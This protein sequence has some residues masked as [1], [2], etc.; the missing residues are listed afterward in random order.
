MKTPAG[1]ECKYFYGDYYRGRDRE[2]CRL[3]GA[4]WTGGLCRACPVPAILRA[5]ACES[6]RLRPEVARPLTAGFKRRVRV[7]TYCEK[8]GRSGF[9]PHVGCGDCHPV[10]SVFEVKQ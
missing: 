3:L 10:P 7:A 9:D 8:T 5:N 2:E 1:T 4:A 6:M